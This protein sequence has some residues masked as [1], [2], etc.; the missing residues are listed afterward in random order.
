MIDGPAKTILLV[1]DEALLALKSKTLL[2]KHNYSVL[3]VMSGEKALEIVDTA[4]IDLILM[5]IDL[6]KGR[7]DG[8]ET[9]QKILRNH[10]IPIIFYT[11]HSEKE[12]VEKVKGITR[13]GYVLK[14]A[15]EFVLLESISMAFELFEANRSILEKEAHYQYM[16]DYSRSS[17]IVLR[18]DQVHDNFVIVECNS[19]AERIEEISREKVLGRTVTDIF[20]AVVHNGLL[21]ALHH[22]HATGQSCSIPEFFY[23][24]GRIC[25][26]KEVFIYQLPAKELVFV[27]RDITEE[28]NNQKELK[29]A[30]AVLEKNERFFRNLFENMNDGII[31]TDRDGVITLVNRVVAEKIG[32]ENSDELI[33]QN[34]VHFYHKPED[35]TRMLH[36]LESSGKLD[37][38]ELPI[39]TMTGDIVWTLCNL[40]AVYDDD[41]EF[42]GIEALVRDMTEKKRIEENEKKQNRFFQTVLDS[43]QDPIAVLDRD[44]QIRHC[45]TL[46]QNIVAKRGF[47]DGKTCFA[48]LFG[49][50]GPCGDCPAEKAFETK[51][52]YSRL[53]ETTRCDGSKR[54]IELSAYP[55]F[56]ESGEVEMVVEYA[57]DITNRKMVELELKQSIEQLYMQTRE[58]RTLQQA[59][60][61]VLEEP[62]FDKAAEKIFYG[63]KS[64]LSATSGYIALIDE[65]DKKYKFIL[66]DVNGGK[67]GESHHLP[68]SIS[69]LREEVWRTG[70]VIVENR[71]Q[72]SEWSRFVPDD[73]PELKNVLIAPLPVDGTVLGIMGFANKNRDFTPDDVSIAESLGKIAALG[74]RNSI[75][76]NLVLERE[77]SLQEALHE[78]DLLMKELNHRVKNNL[79]VVASLIRMKNR[80]LSGAADLTDLQHR[81]DAIRIVHE[82]LYKSDDIRGINL[83]EYVQ[84]LLS[85][86]F[87]SLSSHPVHIHN[88]IDDTVLPAKIVIPLGIIINEIA[89]NAVK[90]GF[91]PDKKAE[92]SIQLI[93]SQGEN[94]QVLTISHSGRDF[95][96]DI[97][98]DNPETMGLRLVSS[99]AGQLDGRFILEQHSP[100]VFS[101]YFPLEMN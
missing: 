50:D 82:K 15:G 101:V 51:A 47:S 80:T 81:I 64:L 25:G 31:R 93:S 16:F 3:H 1:E 73:H 100:P 26:W 57:K 5:D 21:Q 53:H 40:T 62:G 65:E 28:K 54:V 52:I 48:C 27:S 74:L 39:Q 89:T 97:E 7:L 11:S 30:H 19:S 71:F 37:N 88:S 38:Y 60:M 13:Y 94:E 69:G 92:F 36:Q 66:L 77:R 87:S 6:G 98:L 79:M 18:Y 33:G 59:A 8:T 24:D 17:M 75:S 23:D 22:V 20:P 35:R 76:D 61:A 95:P 10:E 70:K 14:S 41:G 4:D 63:A 56:D 86:L 44:F 49:F 9:A 29:I 68:L 42:C 99:L 72:E 78:K 84:D 12:M 67:S 45:N 58:I 43:I 91:L 90:Y 85:T 2:E 55:V 32:C 46:Y 83:K 34:I 96:D